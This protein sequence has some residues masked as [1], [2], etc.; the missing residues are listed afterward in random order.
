MGIDKPQIRMVVHWTLPATPEAYYQEAGRAGR[1]GEFARCVLLWRRGDAELHRR[2]L[3]VT[4][5]PRGLLERIWGQTSQPPGI[6][7][8]VLASAERLRRE[9]RPERGRVDWSPVIERR[10]RAEARIAAIEAYATGRHFRR[11]VL[12]GYFGERL[13]RC[14]GCDRCRR[15]AAHTPQDPPEVRRRLARL[16]AVVGGR[17]GAWGATLLEP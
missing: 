3:D 7:A 15:R 16:Q 5:P 13:D 8:N 2:Q 11:H 1:N 17:R 14:A 9:L 6:P 4:F 10:R 12:V